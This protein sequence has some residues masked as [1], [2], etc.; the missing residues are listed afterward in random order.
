M[1]VLLQ[2]LEKNSTEIVI[3]VVDFE[4]FQENGDMKQERE[5]LSPARKFWTNLIRS[6]RKTSLIWR[7]KLLS[8]SVDSFSSSSAWRLRR[9]QIFIHIIEI[10]KDTDFLLIKL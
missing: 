10:Q 2:Q 7:K 3:W 4:T 9:M 5:N 8:W 1:W 6:P